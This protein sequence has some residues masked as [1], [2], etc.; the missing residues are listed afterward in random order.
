[1]SRVE[2]LALAHPPR[3]AADVLDVVFFEAVANER[4]VEL[5]AA[6]AREDGLAVHVRDETGGGERE[7]VPVGVV[8]AVAHG[9]ERLEHL[10]RNVRVERR[11]AA[12]VH[13]EGVEEHANLKEREEGGENEKGRGCARAG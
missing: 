13:V 6:E 5:V 9:D 1:M 12:R 2:E 11:E 3:V 8:D 7:L 4:E 10:L